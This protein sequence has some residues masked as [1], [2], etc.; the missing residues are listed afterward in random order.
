MQPSLGS[1]QLQPTVHCRPRY[2]IEKQNH[3]FLG[4][5]LGILFRVS[6]VMYDTP[7]VC[8]F[9]F[10]AYSA[11]PQFL[12][13]I[14][15]CQKHLFVKTLH[16]LFKASGDLWTYL[17]HQAFGYAINQNLMSWHLKHYSLLSEECLIANCTRS[18]TNS[19]TA[20][21]L[22]YQNKMLSPIIVS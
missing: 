12:S 18:Y 9:S 8:R 10:M 14:M 22:F 2:K 15:D 7:V 3:Y 17:H 20:N 13:I 21:I 16:G 6:F 19:T 4:S 11:W 5:T 1:C